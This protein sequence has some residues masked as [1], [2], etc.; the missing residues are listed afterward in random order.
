[1]RNKNK[2]IIFGFDDLK[3]FEKS[4]PGNKKEMDMVG[5][6]S[7]FQQMAGRTIVAFERAFLGVK[8]VGERNAQNKES[9]NDQMDY[10]SLTADHRFSL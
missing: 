1:M 3:D 6:L 7:G 9:E 4:G 5:G 10:F 2:G 8:E